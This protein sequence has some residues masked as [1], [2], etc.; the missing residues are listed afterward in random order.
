M[1]IVQRN[2]WGPLD[3]LSEQL[4]L[5]NDSLL[6][7]Q[8]GVRWRPALDISEN[9]ESYVIAMD[10]P[11]VSSDDIEVTLDAGVL[12]IAGSRKLERESSDDGVYRSFERVSGS[13][14]RTLRLPTQS[15]GDEVNAT[16]KDGVLTIFIKKAEAVRPKRIEVKA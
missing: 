12:K 5:F 8:N 7:K 9:A 1:S 3:G 2:L 10:V 11:G 16:V 6:G 4:S 15:L 14:E 13:F